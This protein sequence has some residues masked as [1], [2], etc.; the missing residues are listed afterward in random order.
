MNI[1][2]RFRINTLV[3]NKTYRFVVLFQVQSSVYNVSQCLPDSQHS[4]GQEEKG[5]QPQETLMPKKI[6]ILSHFYAAFFSV[7]NVICNPCWCFLA[8]HCVRTF[9]QKKKIPGG[10]IDWLET[11]PHC[12]FTTFFRLIRLHSKNGREDCAGQS[13]GAVHSVRQE[14]LIKI[15][16]FK[17]KWKISKFL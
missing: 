7:Y 17:F 16:L 4:L 9:L 15:K 14:N 10:L 6:F 1:K 3:L 11:P 8:A 5:R 12:C 2:N 13:S